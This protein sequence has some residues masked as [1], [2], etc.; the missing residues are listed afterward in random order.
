MR[1]LRGIEDGRVVAFSLR[2]NAAFLRS[3][4]TH[5]GKSL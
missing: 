1:I 2:G 4:D 3:G 5:A